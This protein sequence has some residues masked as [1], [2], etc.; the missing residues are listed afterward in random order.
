MKGKVISTCRQDPDNL[1]PS[2]GSCEVQAPSVGL[3]SGRW[4]DS[5]QMGGSAG[6]TRVEERLGCVEFDEML[7]ELS[8]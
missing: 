1:E 3:G 5:G 2:A 6:G 7:L 8:N 4:G